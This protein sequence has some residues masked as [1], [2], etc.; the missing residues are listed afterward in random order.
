ME[1]AVMADQRNLDDPHRSNSSSAIDP[2]RSNQTR[3]DVGHPA[4]LD[5]ELQ[6]DPQMT[7]GPASGGRITV[8]AIAIVLILGAVFYGLNSA[9]FHRAGESSSAHNTAPA[10]PS[11]TPSAPRPNAQPGT[12]TGAAPAHPSPSPAATGNAAPAKAAPPQ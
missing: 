1:A 2:F 11:A 10:S 6:A 8:Y 12:T 3:D 5:G 7:E 4:R 9:S